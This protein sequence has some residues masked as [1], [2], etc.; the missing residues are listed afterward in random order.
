VT[1][2]ASS[3]TTTGCTIHVFDHTGGD[4]GGSVNWV[5]TGE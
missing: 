4:V 5:A 1:A 2:T 3:I